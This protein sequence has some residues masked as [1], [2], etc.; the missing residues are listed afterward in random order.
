MKDCEKLILV[1]YVDIRGIDEIYAPK[2]MED[3]KNAF[4]LDDSIITIF[5][6]I[7]GNSK[8]ECL[9]SVNYIFFKI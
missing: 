1:F 5:I 7:K 6:P 2:Y 3:V 9:N 8:I 4:K